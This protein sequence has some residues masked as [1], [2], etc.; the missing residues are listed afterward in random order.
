MANQSLVDLTERTAT[1]NTDLIHVNSGGSDYKQT[2]ANFLADYVSEIE[3]NSTSALT[4]QVDALPVGS[5]GGA[6]TAKIASYGHQSETGVPENDNYT[7]EVSAFS[8]Q[9]KRITIMS[10][11]SDKTYTRTKLNGTWG[12]WILV[13]RREEVTSLNNS[14]TNNFVTQEFTKSGSKSSN[15]DYYDNI[16]I[17]KSGYTPI[18]IT[19][20]LFGGDYSTRFFLNGATVNATTAYLVYRAEST[21]SFTSNN[22][23]VKIVVLYKKNT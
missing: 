5:Y 9:N 15:T 20:W 1:A 7:V 22:F 16:T 11:I 19:Q 18:G 12:S 8:T 3:F 21:T 14:L 17:T 4:T 6:Y 13:P 2:K 23:S 10:V